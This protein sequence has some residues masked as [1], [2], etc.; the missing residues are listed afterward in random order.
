MTEN[1]KIIQ[2]I[3]KKQNKYDLAIKLENAK[4]D[5]KEEHEW[6]GNSYQI[7]NINVHPNYFL[8]LKNINEKDKELLLEIV[9]GIYEI[10]ISLIEFKINTNVNIETISDTLYIFV[11]EAGDFDF[12]SNGSKHYLFTFLVKKRPFNLHE[13]IASYRYSLLE[14]NLDP[15]VE[16]RLDIEAFH[17]CEDNNYIKNEL[18]NI[19]STFD[20]NSVKAYSYIL[21]KPKVT[22]EKRNHK[23]R[24]YIDNLSFAIQKLLNELNINKNFIIITDRLPVQNNK[25][26][27]IGAL[28]KGIKEYLKSKDLDKQLRYD[29]F[30]HCSASSV[31]LQIADYICWAIFRKFERNDDTYY[32]RI[33]KYLIKIDE[34]TK[35][36]QEVYYEK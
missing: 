18:F 29:I 8:E 27:Q 24:F 11:D 35:D 25:N 16:K 26:K 14:R 23:D 17:A 7:I 6:G 9:N 10:D 28:K 2:N 36:R 12:S 21:E 3:L 1:I 19:I 4:F 30:H 22:P 20:E 31:N 13:Y 34:M 15:L 32:K 33:E 5:L